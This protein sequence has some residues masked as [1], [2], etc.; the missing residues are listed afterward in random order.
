MRGG[1]LG[2]GGASGGARYRLKALDG[3]TS[4]TVGKGM[5][6]TLD[7]VGSSTYTSLPHSCALLP[8]KVEL[9]ENTV[10]AVSS[11]NAAPWDACGRHK[12]RTIV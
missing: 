7:W 9:T 1:E 6:Y 3:Y 8:E 11:E 5:K 12:T 4:A 10:A 2:V